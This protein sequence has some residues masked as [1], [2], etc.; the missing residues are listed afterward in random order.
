LWHVEVRRNVDRL[1]VAVTSRHH[2][3]CTVGVN[4]RWRD[5]VDQTDDSVCEQDRALKEEDG[6]N[7]PEDRLRDVHARPAGGLLWVALKRPSWS[8]GSL[9]VEDCREARWRLA[10]VLHRH[11]LA[12][13]FVVG[14]GRVGRAEGD[15]NFQVFA[16]GVPVGV[17]V[18]VDLSLEVLVERHGVERSGALVIRHAE[19]RPT[20]SAAL[21]AGHGFADRGLL[22]ARGV[23]GYAVLLAMVLSKLISVCARERVFAERKKRWW[24]CA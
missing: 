4:E 8:G 24:C 2:N 3:T 1:R 11:L 14:L 12:V 20:V 18:A 15:R 17:H 21:K 19:C 13:L 7:R 10:L 16:G 23:I 5:V 6:E 22:Y 9:G